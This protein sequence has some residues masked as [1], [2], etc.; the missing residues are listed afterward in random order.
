M[1]TIDQGLAHLRRLI[2][3]KW[4]NKNDNVATYIYSDGTRL[5]LTPV[6]VKAWA[7]AIVCDPSICCICY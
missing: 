5:Q 3:K 1:T 7:R 4:G 2:I 6:M